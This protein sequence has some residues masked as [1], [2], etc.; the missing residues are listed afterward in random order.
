VAAGVPAPVFGWL[1]VRAIRFEGKGYA[2]SSPFILE[3]NLGI[4][5]WLE[6]AVITDVLIRY[7]DLPRRMAAAALVVSKQMP[8]PTKSSSL[9]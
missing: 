7:P 5:K 9:S 2:K 6:S 8:I 1:T 3:G 4:Q